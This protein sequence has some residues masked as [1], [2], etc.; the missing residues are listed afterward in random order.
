MDWKVGVLVVGAVAVFALTFRYEMVAVTPGG[1]GINGYAY[2]L[3]RWTGEAI[4]LFGGKGQRV[5]IEQ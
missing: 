2:R 1:E 3:D 4:V 5:Q